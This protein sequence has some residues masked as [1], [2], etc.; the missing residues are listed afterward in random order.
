MSL[1]DRIRKI[2]E[3]KQLGQ[4]F[5]QQQDLANKISTGVAGLSGS[6]PGLKTLTGAT[7]PPPPQEQPEW[8]LGQEV[9]NTVARVPYDATSQ[10]LDMAG[11]VTRSPA[12]HNIS[13]E[14]SEDARRDYPS[15]ARQITSYDDF[16]SMPWSDIAKT[17]ISESGSLGASVISMAVPGMLAKTVIAKVAPAL[18][19]ARKAVP[20]MGKLID[21][22]GG[23]QKVAEAVSMLFG[24]TLNQGGGMANQALQ[25]TGEM[26]DFS[27]I[28]KWAVPGAMMEITTPLIML[29]SFRKAATPAQAATAEA[30][31][32]N[33][34][35]L[36]EFIMET[37]KNSGTEFFTNYAEEM[38]S[39]MS[40]E[41]ARGASATEAIANVGVD[42]DA[43]ARGWGVGLSSV[44]GSG[45]MATGSGIVGRMTRS[46]PAD[47]TTVTPDQAVDFIKAMLDEERT[48]QAALETFSQPESQQETTQPEQPS[49]SKESE[50][51]A[52]ADVG[53]VVDKQKLQKK[54]LVKN[55]R[56]L[57]QA[58]GM[59]ETQFDEFSEQVVGKNLFDATA[60]ELGTLQEILTDQMASGNVVDNTSMQ[61]LPPQAPDMG[62]QQGMQPS[63]PTAE[64]QPTAV[65]QGLE[66]AISRIQQ[67]QMQAARPEMGMSQPQEMGTGQVDEAEFQRMLQERMQFKEHD[68]SQQTIEV[69]PEPKPEP[70]SD[71]QKLSEINETLDSI[72]DY[73]DKVDEVRQTQDLDPEVIDRVSEMQKEKKALEK[74]KKGLIK[75]ITAREKEEQKEARKAGAKVMKI[76]HTGGTVTS[77]IQE[78]AISIAVTDGDGVNKYTAYVG[79]DGRLTRTNKDLFT[80]ED[81]K[82]L[83]ALRDKA[84]ELEAA[85]NNL[86][87]YRTVVRPLQDELAEMVQEFKDQAEGAV[88]I[89]EVATDAPAPQMPTEQEISQMSEAQL[90]KA[91]SDLGA[92]E[93]ALPGEYTD[94][95]RDR[96]ADLLSAITKRQNEI[97]D[98]KFDEQEMAQPTTTPDIGKAGELNVPNLAEAL[99]DTVEGFI[100]ADK[101]MTNPQLEAVMREL[102]VDTK[103]PK[104]NHKLV[105]EAI[106]GALVKVIRKNNLWNNF[107]AILNLYKNQPLLNMKTADSVRRQAYSTPVTLANIAGRILGLT[108]NNKTIYEPTAGTGLLLSAINDPSGQ[109]HNYIINELDSTRSDIL[110]ALYPDSQITSEDA[111]KFEPPVK[112]DAVVTNPPFGGLAKFGVESGQVEVNPIKGGKGESIRIAKVDHLIAWRALSNMKDDGKA[113]L[114]MGAEQDNKITGQQKTFMNA[115]YNQFNITGHFEIDGDFY[116]RQGAGW[117]VVVMTIDGIKNYTSGREFIKAPD[118]VHRVPYS[119]GWE[120]VNKYATENITVGEYVNRRLGTPVSAGTADQGTRTDV[121]DT[122]D[123]GVQ[124]DRADGRGERPDSLTG[125]V[126]RVKKQR[127][128]R[129][130]GDRVD[131]QRTDAVS[132]KRDSI[133]K[134]TDEGRGTTDKTIGDADPTRPNDKSVTL[135][136]I[137]KDQ[138]VSRL[139]VMHKPVAEGFSLN[140]LA[141]KN[142]ENPMR[143][144]AE[145]VLKQV[146]KADPKIKTLNDYVAKELK[147]DS[148]DDITFFAAEQVESLA[149]AFYQFN[150]KGGFICADQTGIGKGRQAAGAILW[151]VRNGKLP[152]F[153]TEKAGLYDDIYRDMVD[154]GQQDLRPFIMNA[155]AAMR[156][157][158]ANNELQTAYK[159]DAKTRN[160]V[161]GRMAKGDF[162]DFT[163]ENKKFDYIVSTYSQINTLTKKQMAALSRMQNGLLVLDEAHVAAGA[164]ASDNTDDTSAQM[165]NIL[166]LVNPEKSDAV[167]YLSATWA[168]TP[169][170]IPIYQRAFGQANVTTDEIKSAFEKGTVAMQAMQT[171]AMADKGSYVRREQNYAGVSWK[172]T[173]TP[174]ESSEGK[175]QWKK[176]DAAMSGVRDMIG[177]DSTITAALG[178]VNLVDLNDIYNLGI[179]ERF[180]GADSESKAHIASSLDNPSSPFSTVHNYVSSFMTALKADMAADRALQLLKE[181]KKPFITLQNTMESRMNSIMD[182]KGLSIGDTFDGT[183]EDFLI[184]FV[185]SMTNIT[186]KNPTNSKDTMRVKIPVEAL[187][188]QVQQQI[189]DVRARIEGLGLKDLPFSPIDKITHALTK[190][191]YKVNE[192][193]GRSKVL[194]YSK[195]KNGAPTI[196]SRTMTGA[197][198][199]RLLAEFNNGDADALIVN[200]SGAVGLSAHSSE[201]FK[202]QRQRTMLILQPFGDINLFTQ[203][204]GRIFRTGGIYNEKNVTSRIDGK[205]A[206]YGTPSYEYLQSSLAME[207][208]PAIR[209]ESKMKS[210]NA[211]TSSNEEGHQTVSDIDL[212]NRYGLMIL[213]RWL[214][215]NRPQAQMMDYDG[216][217]AKNAEQVTGRAAIIPQED[218]TRMMAEVTVAYND[219]MDFLNSVGENELVVENYSNANA[220]TLE[221]RVIYGEEGSLTTPP[222]YVERLRMNIPGKPST[223]DVAQNR[224]KQSKGLTMDELKSL[225]PQFDAYMKDLDNKI[226]EYA[227]KD[228]KYPADPDKIRFYAEYI[229]DKAASLTPG[230]R[231]S[232]EYVDGD[233]KEFIQGIVT[234]ISIRKPP[235]GYVMN[236]YLPSNIKITIATPGK[237]GTMVFSMAFL[238]S[239]GLSSN[240]MSEHLFQA[241]WNSEFDANLRAT[242]EVYALTGDMIKAASMF[243]DKNVRAI[244]FGRKDGTADYAWTHKKLSEDNIF[245]VV[246]PIEKMTTKDIESPDTKIMSSDPANSVQIGLFEKL[247]GTKTHQFKA[248]VDKSPFQIRLRKTVKLSSD[249]AMNQAL[250]QLVKSHPQSPGFKIV[251]HGTTQYYVSD[252]IPFSKK[253]AVVEMIGN[254]TQAQGKFLV[255][256]AT[257]TV[258][259]QDVSSLL[260]D[261]SGLH[262]RTGSA[263]PLNVMVDWAANGML[264][265]LESAYNY[266]VRGGRNIVTWLGTV[267]DGLRT[268]AAKAWR[269]ARKLLAISN[270]GMFGK[271]GGVMRFDEL[272]RA[273]RDKVQK[274]QQSDSIVPPKAEIV[275]EST[276][277]RVE[278]FAAEARKTVEEAA[279]PEKKMT[280]RQLL[281]RLREM[282]KLNRFDYQNKRFLLDLAQRLPV[283]FRVQAMKDITMARTVTQAGNAIDKIDR[284]L[285]RAD[286]VKATKRLRESLR[287]AKKLRPEFQS[288]ANELTANLSDRGAMFEVL[289]GMTKYIEGN[290]TILLSP[291]TM[292][293]INTLRENK[294]KRLSANTLNVLADA[295]DTFKHLSDL[296]NSR[297]V[298]D[299]SKTI[300]ETAKAIENH[301]PK[302]TKLT[303]A[304]GK[305]GG[306]KYALRIGMMQY[307]SLTELLGETGRKVFYNDVRDGYSKALDL[308][309][310][311]KDKVHRVLDAI[312]LDHADS[313]TQ[314]W[315]K[316]TLSKKQT[317]LDVD[318]TR[319][320][321]MNLIANLLDSSTYAEMVTRMSK[322]MPG[323]KPKLLKRAGFKLTRDKVAERVQITA[324]QASYLIDSMTDAEKAVVT[325]MRGFINGDLID[326]VN[327]TWVELFGYELA[328]KKD[329][330]PR[331][332][333]ITAGIMTGFREWVLSSVEDLGI[334]KRRT[335]SKEAVLIGD[336]ADVYQNHIKKAS[337][338]AGLAVPVRNIEMVLSKDKLSNKLADR[339]GTQYIDE[340]KNMMAAM[341][342][343]GNIDGGEMN[344]IMSKALRNLG[345]GFLGLNVR[346]GLRQFGGVFT[347][348]SELNPVNLMNSLSYAFNKQTSKE[349]DTWSSILRNRYDSAGAKLV[350]PMFD[351]DNGL[352]TTKTD[353]LRHKAMK[354]LHVCDRGVAQIIWE[355]AKTEIQQKNP[356][357]KGDA[358]MREVARRAEEVVSRTQNVT[359]VLD[360][361]GIALQ[362]RKNPWL[363]PFVMFQSQGNSVYNVVNRIGRNYS[364]G[365]LSP[366][367]ALGMLTV[368]MLGNA[369]F[370]SLVGYVSFRKGRKK[371]PEEKKA[372]AVF[373]AVTDVIQSNINMIY[374]GSMTRP[375]IQHLAKLTAGRPSFGRLKAEHVTFSVFNSTLETISSSLQ[376]IL[377]AGEKFERGPRKDQYKSKAH[378]ENAIRNLIRGPGVALG[379]PAPAI[380]EAL[381]LFQRFQ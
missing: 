47:P 230:T 68:P 331:R 38:I 103:D 279:V 266:L 310:A 269:D 280:S 334:F 17:A 49:V 142:L 131:G 45:A 136:S 169:D 116:K 171:A 186:I 257:R 261:P 339:F 128:P 183:Y 60:Q 271:R 350:T 53:A 130:S 10:M 62:M 237:T 328:T 157:T 238:E 153:F 308:W 109:K 54:K 133:G 162:S 26:Q 290:D 118:K 343:L 365:E 59:D 94:E 70:V 93:V 369:M 182:D 35:K 56:S 234:D 141:P 13:K 340:V 341:Q 363:K 123:T 304:E 272:V 378:A 204:L 198:K 91:Q 318:M 282:R 161:L 11:W 239:T 353:V 75:A 84:A 355:A 146:Q 88:G 312:G 178:K 321:K 324:E 205:P 349:I 97:S 315:F 372:D 219:L 332:R 254:L 263:G 121:N 89:K 14:I 366:H 41:E 232:G 326:N 258:G 12:L 245:E 228:R 57:M 380:N 200:Q 259:K 67:P 264:D 40:L 111:V 148:S 30:L 207:Q 247:P 260:R 50:A 105:Q 76:R 361:S 51:V 71:R 299:K 194:N 319:G 173:V 225:Q 24:S 292:A 309:H 190:A 229:M 7:P 73:L 368:V 262:G 218:Q 367:K 132:D 165:A 64:L 177:L 274:K 240:S 87:D 43:H 270:T 275:V 281:T 374:G 197:D 357:L 151:A 273:A 297:I 61:P 348:M 127:Q 1:F 143:R 65:P 314:D 23:N 82:Q 192:I 98:A 33:V 379:I 288:A 106:E 370:S 289:E 185:N 163:G 158:D 69:A 224:A 90:K 164:A 359:S 277:A 235:E 187:P 342:D 211:N 15:A 160:E 18:L 25:D 22:M 199:A 20:V 358:L 381:Y 110:K 155:D 236:P 152:V 377:E 181:G 329:H 294:P 337:T 346:S 201:K 227:K 360:M 77:T 244:Q 203:M 2:R 287:A 63:E 267:S 373:K 338:F 184:G 295:L 114:I 102:G 323:K 147:F 307:G 226:A 95:Q 265:L 189:E 137:D 246:K 107:D 108:G 150:Q 125:A 140:T 212:H 296:E 193:T 347:A 213:N 170:N 215:N 126:D 42:L 330:W 166:K 284:L 305:V 9:L 44:V 78:G 251:K 242:K 139:Q 156:Y 100:D 352:F 195:T 172:R 4:A 46:I 356:E 19:K 217:D 179:P 96:A 86:E 79:N 333:D 345:V 298:A 167:M 210:L 72:D 300:A 16:S 371:D 306:I 99:V 66:Q 52:P 36:K 196:E 209:L 117:P 325:T 220:E 112:V 253:K 276:K 285:R 208:R 119:E 316:E 27:Q 113:V 243:K 248:A 231:L 48:T 327:G 252:M 92:I 268:H 145:N 302:E 303:D 313:S 134:A 29:K 364:K 28:L 32:N 191:G 188:L 104:Y 241:R 216:G 249:I 34:P 175:R 149:M 138:K 37:L 21:E 375:L 206:F 80:T 74:E 39:Q 154:I 351:A 362:S 176:G 283:E 376:A 6:V 31:K 320:E 291:E 301:L 81:P 101:P 129:D 174:T 180:I 159:V 233:T 335:T 317:G 144:A 168:K 115:L 85:D 278:E 5:G 256:D 221:R 55:V 83:A 250:E 3:E 202:D 58:I 120:G 223:I 135:E 344:K 124:A 222:V 122:G 293:M 286:R 214:A 8:K 311:G 322:P 336:I 255:N 354:I